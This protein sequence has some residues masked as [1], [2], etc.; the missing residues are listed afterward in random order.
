GFFRAQAEGFRRGTDRFTVTQ[1]ARYAVNAIE[2]DV[3]TAGAHLT[4]GQPTLVYADSMAVA[5]NTD[6]ATNDSDDPFAVYYEP[7]A[8]DSSVVSLGKSQAFYIAGSSFTY[9]DTTYESAGGSGAK[10]EAETI[11]FMFR[12]D[13][14][15][16]R[17]DDYMLLRQVNGDAPELVARHL[18][19]SPAGPFLSYLKETTSSSG[20]ATVDTLPTG[21]L[22]LFHSAPIHG[23]TADTGSAAIIDSLRAVQIRVVATDEKAGDQE[24]T[25]SMS[26]LVRLP[27]AGVVPKKTCGD[28]PILGQSLT[29]TPGNASSGDPQITLT[30]DAATDETGGEHDIVRYVIYR[31]PHAASEWGNPLL[32]IPSGDST[33]TYVDKQLLPDSTYDYG[34]AAQDCTPSLSTMSTDEDVTAPLPL[35]PPGG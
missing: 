13:T 3:R 28:E 29:A 7:E 25:E 16:D 14:S 4:D 20:Q 8:A 32:S 17:T 12:P 24:H 15:T 34:L 10:S 11:S 31:R 23:S 27:N 2:K 1:N 35:P 26:R 6:F 30:W 22:P 21:D 33:Y 18:I 5:F 9:P 19:R